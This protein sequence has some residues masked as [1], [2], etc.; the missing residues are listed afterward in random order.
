MDG[1]YITYWAN[2]DP[3]WEYKTRTLYYEL[4]NRANAAGDRVVF[5]RQLNR[6]QLVVSLRELERETGIQKDTVKRIIS[7]I[8]TFGSLKVE[9]IKTNKKGA[10]KL[11]L[12]TLLKS[13]KIRDN[14]NDKICDNIN[15]PQNI[16]NTEV[17]PLS[18]IS[19]KTRDAT[20]NETEYATY[21]LINN[22]NNICCGGVTRAREDERQGDESEQRQIADE[23]IHVL[24]TDSQSAYQVGRRN[25]TMETARALAMAFASQCLMNNDPREHGRRLVLHFCYWY[26]K[27]KQQEQRKQAYDKRAQDNREATAENVRRTTIVSNAIINGQLT[28]EQAFAIADAQCSLSSPPQSIPIDEGLRSTLHPPKLPEMGS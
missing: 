8:E 27:R 18:S 16:D 13:D 24:E 15:E 1:Y 28:L 3:T 6:G 25:C 14:I 23:L 21:T 22:T 17:N 10:P 20:T 7:K 19:S 9:L 11:Q 26:D 4:V 2:I 5:G 12:L